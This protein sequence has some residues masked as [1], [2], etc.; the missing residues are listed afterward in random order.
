MTNILK[1]KLERVVRKQKPATDP[2]FYVKTRSSVQSFFR[3][4]D[5]I[6]R[7][8][9]SNV[10]YQVPCQDCDET[11]IGK[12]ERQMVR[13]LM[14]HGAPKQLLDNEVV[15][16]TQYRNINITNDEQK[17][18]SSHTYSTMD[19][20]GQDVNSVVDMV[21]KVTSNNRMVTRCVRKQ[22]LN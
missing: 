6:N 10:V 7:F 12:T 2:C 22:Q 9:R 17:I 16:N 3:I 21:S 8:M 4:K 20:N 5:P 1:Q 15:H 13:R 18:D 19:N 14:E 11:Y